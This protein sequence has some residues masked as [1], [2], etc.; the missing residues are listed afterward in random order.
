MLDL[1]LIALFVA[2]SLLLN[3]YVFR[4]SAFERDCFLTGGIPSDTRKLS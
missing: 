4:G 1:A 2:G 3:T